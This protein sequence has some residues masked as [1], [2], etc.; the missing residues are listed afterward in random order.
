LFA[1]RGVD[2][3]SVAASPLRFRVKLTRNPSR[4]QPDPFRYMLGALDH[5]KLGAVKVLSDLQQTTLNFV[6]VDDHYVVFRQSTKVGRSHPREAIALSDFSRCSPVAVAVAPPSHC[7]GPL[8]RP[9]CTV[10][11]P[12]RVQS[13]TGRGVTSERPLLPAGNAGVSQDVVI[14]RSRC[15]WRENGPAANGPSATAVMAST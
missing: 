9:R 14:V 4:C 3:A 2:A 15:S 13:A 12:Y 10:A 11:P 5:R 8:Q 1:G 6:A 7:N